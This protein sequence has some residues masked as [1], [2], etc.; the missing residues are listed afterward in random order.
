MF[1]RFQFQMMPLGRLTNIVCCASNGILLY[2]NVADIRETDVEL[3]GDEN[4]AILTENVRLGPD[5][6]TIGS[7]IYVPNDIQVEIHADQVFYLHFYT[8]VIVSRNYKNGD[9]RVAL[10]DQQSCVRYSLDEITRASHK[11]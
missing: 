2:A 9:K 1:S 10:P 8:R 4:I 7:H 6:I 11:L 5:C 3:N